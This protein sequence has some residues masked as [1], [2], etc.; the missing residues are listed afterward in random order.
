MA[1]TAKVDFDKVYSQDVTF[2]E[3]SSKYSEGMQEILGGLGRSGSVAA[4]ALRAS[5]LQWEIWWVHCQIQVSREDDT[6]SLYSKI[7]DHTRSNLTAHCTHYHQSIELEKAPD[8]VATSAA[9]AAAAIVDLMASTPPPIKA[10]WEW[11]KEKPNAD[12][13]LAKFAEQCIWRIA[14][15]EAAQRVG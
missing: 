8:V 4:K 6:M 12:K 1:K 13:N 3:V 7:L 10:L 5:D 2:S 11:L 9:R 15:D 14:R